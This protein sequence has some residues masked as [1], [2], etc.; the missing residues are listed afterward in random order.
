VV[1]S[2]GHRNCSGTAHLGKLN[3]RLPYA[4]IVGTS[5]P[6]KSRVPHF[7]QQFPKMEMKGNSKLTQFWRPRF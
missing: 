3:D 6:G 7:A 4:G 2:L 1:N 5:N